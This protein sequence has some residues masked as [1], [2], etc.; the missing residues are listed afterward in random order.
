M[1][2]ALPV[3]AA[4]LDPATDACA[5][6]GRHGQPCAGAVLGKTPRPTA[7]I[8]GPR[9]AVSARTKR[10]CRGLQDAIQV[11]EQAERRSTGAGVIE[12]LR[13]DLLSL[14]KRHRQLG[15]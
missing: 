1:S 13:Q 11:S 15:C 10:E 6:A 12:S 8:Q 5:Q 4:G 7:A 9:H 2:T 14:R 3:H